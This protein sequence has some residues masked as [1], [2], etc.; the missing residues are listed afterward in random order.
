MASSGRALLSS[1]IVH[2]ESLSSPGRY[3]R[4]RKNANG[5]KIRKTQ[6]PGFAS[7]GVEEE[8]KGNHPAKYSYVSISLPSP[9]TELIE[10]SADIL[11]ESV[12]SKITHLQPP[13]GDVALGAPSRKDR[14]KTDR[15]EFLKYFF[16]AKRE[17]SSGKSKRAWGK[18]VRPSKSVLR[19]RAVAAASTPQTSDQ[20]GVFD[21]TA[22]M[23]RR[24]GLP[25][26][27]NMEEVTPGPGAYDPMPA[28]KIVMPSLKFSQLPR[29]GIPVSKLHESEADPR[30]DGNGFCESTKMGRTIT[31][32]SPT[33]RTTEK[34]TAFE[35]AVPGPKYNPYPINKKRKKPKGGSRNKYSVLECSRDAKKTMKW[36]ENSCGGNVRVPGDF[37]HPVGKT[38]KIRVASEEM[39]S[40][41]G[42]TP[43][44]EGRVSSTW[45]STKPIRT[46]TRR[47]F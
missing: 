8:R 6:T 28:P 31:T 14:A 30:R 38:M 27:G 10:T 19:A 5:K 43:S 33:Y 26:N 21:I 16:E 4:R 13:A 20:F 17:N 32:Q 22:R 41:A 37:L 12:G 3:V 7:G 39:H 44:L 46:F 29:Q 36:I 25:H 40:I 1:S 47:S 9:Q 35:T 2:V 11:E 15:M 34:R 18:I 24:L 23:K 42:Y 45:E